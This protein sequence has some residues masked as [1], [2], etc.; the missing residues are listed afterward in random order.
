ML[1]DTLLEDCV[2][3]V[4][5]PL[6]TDLARWID[7]WERNGVYD[8]GADA[9]MGEFRR[10]GIG[11]KEG[12]V[13]PGA[14]QFGE[15]IASLK[16]NPS[17]LITHKMLFL[18]RM[19]D[20]FSWTVGLPGLAPQRT[21]AKS[22][23]VGVFVRSTF[24]GLIRTGLENWVAAIDKTSSDI[25]QLQT[26]SQSHTISTDLINWSDPSFT[27]PS[28]EQLSSVTRDLRSVCDVKVDKDSN[29]ATVNLNTF[30]FACASL[31]RECYDKDGKLT[32]VN[33]LRFMLDYCEGDDSTARGVWVTFALA[34]F[35]SPVL[36]LSATQISKMGKSAGSAVVHIWELWRQLGNSE[37]PAVLVH[38]ERQIWAL[39]FTII[40]GTEAETCLASFVKY[41][42]SGLR[43]E[44][45]YASASTWFVTGPSVSSSIVTETTQATGGSQQSDALAG[46][47]TSDDI[48]DGRMAKKQKTAHE[49]HTSSIC[50][51]QQ[52]QFIDTVPTRARGSHSTS[53]T[54]STLPQ[55]TG[56]SADKTHPVNRRE[57][58]LALFE[59]HQAEIAGLRAEKDQVHA[60]LV[61][62]R[63][64]TVARLL[65]VLEQDP[66]GQDI[67][68][69]DDAIAAVER[70]QARMIAETTELS[71]NLGRALHRATKSESEV[72]QLKERV[73]KLERELAE[74]KEER[75]LDHETMDAIFARS[76][77]TQRSG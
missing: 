70:R 18:Y 62:L 54:S 17:V 9:T 60:S 56:V 14:H 61:E 77:K 24:K 73:D 20:V 57:I 48:G 15:N 72:D 47:S 64:M 55:T 74:V 34:L 37:R 3:T 51:L 40:C 7:H 42:T 35:V 31:L 19:I 53:T 33:L 59:R 46:P 22:P 32:N 12:S 66:E 68:D 6:L 23:T 5:W 38:T 21:V 71:T 16:G 25:L 30:A 27:F 63:D 44:P 52:G 45:N 1:D 36:L 43:S 4:G 29:A 2:R 26:V 11:E 58:L 76:A 67:G 39:I 28:R 75:M 49:D 41:W 65:E 50:A 69:I 13:M 10:L 8:I